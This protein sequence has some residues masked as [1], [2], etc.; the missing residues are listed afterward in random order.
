MKFKRGLSIC[1]FKYEEPDVFL[2][3][4]Q[5]SVVF[6]RGQI[7]KTFRAQFTQKLDEINKTKFRDS[8]SDYPG[9]REVR[10][11]VVCNKKL[12]L[13]CVVFH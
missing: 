4:Y 5:R 1:L 10:S 8:L 3:T 11:H 7:L 2:K 13:L 9:S 12:E 6:T